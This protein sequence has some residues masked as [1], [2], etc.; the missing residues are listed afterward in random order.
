MA[1]LLL[2]GVDLT[3]IP[4]LSASFDLGGTVKDHCIEVYITDANASITAITVD[5]QVRCNKSDS[6]IT[7][8]EHAFTAAQLTALTAKINVL[9]EPATEIKVN[10]SVATSAGAGDTARVWYHPVPI[11]K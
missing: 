6:F 8:K 4:Q 2:D 9:D 5:L 1:I 11:T 10:I 3:S 7:V